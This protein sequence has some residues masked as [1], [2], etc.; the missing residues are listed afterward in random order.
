MLHDQE[1]YHC[2]V[3]HSVA[4]LNLNQNAQA[5]VETLERAND[6]EKTNDWMKAT[7]LRIPWGQTSLLC[8][9]GEVFIC[10][11]KD[12]SFPDGGAKPSMKKM[13]L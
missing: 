1:F 2:L 7:H 8:T 6:N 10:N 13:L 12:P 4:Q 5:F 3:S 9:S 11:A